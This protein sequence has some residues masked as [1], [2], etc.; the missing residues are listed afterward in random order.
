MIQPIRIYGDPIL[1]QECAKV[2]YFTSEETSRVVA[3]LLDTCRATPN[4]AGL[5]A[6]Q[7]GV[8]QRIAVV[9]TIFDSDTDAFVVLINPRVASYGG[10]QLEEQ[11]GCLSIPGHRDKVTRPNIVTVDYQNELG[12]VRSIRGTGIVARALVH[13][14]SHLDGRLFI[15]GFGSAYCA[16]VKEWLDR[17][18]SQQSMEEP[19][20]QTRPALSID[21]ATDAAPKNTEEAS[22]LPETSF[23]QAEGPEDNLSDDTSG[24]MADSEI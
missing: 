18:S 9:R 14:I 17:Q 11:E 6:P 13:E 19:I 21:S 15:H 22:A 12:E 5:A 16:A 1:E 8:L 24:E 3:D 23:V 20:E 4:C 2:D 7:I 10:G